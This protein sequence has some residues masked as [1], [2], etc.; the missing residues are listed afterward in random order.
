MPAPTELVKGNAVVHHRE[1]ELARETTDQKGNQ[2]GRRQDGETMG[3]EFFPVCG[4]RLQEDHG[5]SGP[6]DAKRRT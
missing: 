5:I 3:S 4:E 1:S 6:M 2:L